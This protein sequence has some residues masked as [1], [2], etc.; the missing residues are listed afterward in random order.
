MA[1][2][3]DILGVFFKAPGFL[4]FYYFLKKISF[5]DSDWV[6]PPSQDAIVTTRIT[7]LGNR[8]IRTTKPNHLKQFLGGKGW[9][10]PWPMISGDVERN[11]KVSTRPS[12]ALQHP[13]FVWTPSTWGIFQSYN[14]FLSAAGSSQTLR[15]TIT[16]F[17]ITVCKKIPSRSF[18]RSAPEKL[19]GPNRKGSS[20]NHHFWR[21]YVKLL[22]GIYI[23]ISHILFVGICGFLFW[24]IKADSNR[25]EAL[26]S[27]N[28]QP[29]YST[30]EVR[31]FPS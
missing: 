22:G 3:S 2:F 10:N 20:S 7:C 5:G 29:I 6:Y 14:F 31:K 15:I 25:S 9:H 26:W 8:G 18:I 4:S 27:W 19:P 21:G 24:T 1:P 17:W 11:K 28:Q 30:R 23:Y 13:I 12:L 16:C